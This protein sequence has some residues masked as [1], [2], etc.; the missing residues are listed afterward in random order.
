MRLLL[1]LILG[2]AFTQPS[3]AQKSKSLWF[4]QFTDESHVEVTY[5]GNA[6]RNLREIRLSSAMATFKYDRVMHYVCG[7][8]VLLSPS[9]FQEVDGT[10]QREYPGKKAGDE[11]LSSGYEQ[12]IDDMFRPGKFGLTVE[13]ANK[14]VG[15]INAL[16]A[17]KGGSVEGPSNLFM[18]ISKSSV[19]HLLPA[20]FSRVKDKVTLWTESLP[21][22]TKSGKWLGES[23]DFEIMDKA[24]GRTVTKLLID[25]SNGHIGTSAFYE[26]DKDGSVKDSNSISEAAMNYRETVPGSVGE[27]WV[28][29]ACM[30]E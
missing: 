8:N 17:L 5:T 19:T 24:K 9:S 10:D 2:V 22:L 14:L 12:T 30:I 25:C 3:I 15:A 4:H 16:C 6:W 1:L 23:M 13:T 29:F 18:S 20:R 26:Y 7:R 21:F 28:A 11:I 27:S